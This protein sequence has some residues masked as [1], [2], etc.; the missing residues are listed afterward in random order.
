MF[1]ILG[2]EEILEQTQRLFKE[3]ENLDMVDTQTN[4]VLPWDFEN[5]DLNGL[6][7]SSENL[8]SW[9]LSPEDDNNIINEGIKNACFST[10]MD[11]SLLSTFENQEDGVISLHGE[12]SC[13]SDQLT[14]T[15]EAQVV[16]PEKDCFEVL[17]NPNSCV[18]NPCFGT[19]SCETSL[20]SSSMAA[21]DFTTED[22]VLTSLY[23]MNRSMLGSSE[24]SFQDKLGNS[25]ESMFNPFVQLLHGSKI[26]TEHLSEL[27]SMD[28]LCQRFASP[29]HSTC[30][31]N[32][33]L[34]NSLFQSLEFNPTCAAISDDPLKNLLDGH[35]T[36][37]LMH[38]FESNA[39]LD[40]VGELWGNMIA[41]MVKYS[42]SNIASFECKSEFKNIVTPNSTKK[43]LFAELGIEELLNGGSSFEDQ[44]STTKKRGTDS[45]GSTNPAS[46]FNKTNHLVHNKKEMFSKSVVGSWMD[47]S[48]S[49]NGV[50]VV[51]QKPEEST[52]ISRKRARP[53]ESTRP[54]PKDR[55]QI[56]DRIK[57]LRGIIP[58][59]G[60]VNVG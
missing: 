20:G 27:C 2:R 45:C 9:N 48:Q 57:E 46:N 1:Q 41:P 6:L 33:P 59:G 47:Q 39:S 53:G 16:L 51:P 4:M 3:I 10:S 11:N 15:T 54:R 56:Q 32:T 24:G 25:L 52:K 8:C 49:F 50:K 23:S 19:Q 13:L 26:S 37:T 18:E 7:A 35:Q 21:Q 58:S 12:S 17:L 38:A 22:S 36:P 29:E 34:E 30:A 14:T 42:P 60:K 5:F 43:G 55:Q 31:T 40:F 28:D 44:I